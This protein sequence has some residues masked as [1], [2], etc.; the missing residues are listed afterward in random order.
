MFLHWAWFRHQLSDPANDSARSRTASLPTW[1]TPNITHAI[2]QSIHGCPLGPLTL[3]ESKLVLQRGR[4]ISIV[5]SNFVPLSQFG[6]LWQQCHDQ[7]F[8]DMND[9]N[10]LEYLA[11]YH[12]LGM[13]EKTLQV[14][15][16]LVES[17]TAYDLILSLKYFDL[18]LLKLLKGKIDL[19]NANVQ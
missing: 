18:D 9:G 11:L 16:S 14:L 4:E 3:D 7:V 5:D 2:L 13:T 6:A 8:P 17:K 19:V 1:I 10:R 12:E 15:D